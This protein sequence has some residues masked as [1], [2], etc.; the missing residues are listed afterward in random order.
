MKQIGL[1]L[2][3]YHDTHRRFPVGAWPTTGATSWRFL[4][5]PYLEQTS[6]YDLES[7]ARAA[8]T[9]INF[10]LAW[11]PPYTQADFNAY[12][13]PF[14]DLALPVYSCPSSALPT[15]YHIGTNWEEVRTQMMMYV[16]IMGAYPDPLGRANMSYAPER[17]GYATNNGCLLLNESIGIGAITDGTSNTVIIGE[18][19]GNRLYPTVTKISNYFSGW[20]GICCTKKRVGEWEQHHGLGEHI[21]GSSVVA[22]FHTPNPTS[23]GTEANNVWK[24]NT[25]L[26]SYHPG[27]VHALLADGSARFMSDTIGLQTMRNICARDS[28]AAIGE[29]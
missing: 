7:S 8:G 6:L 3:L 17:G 1:A 14:F 29:W 10:T 4:L 16:G 11:K 24:F 18:Q 2:H 28:G 20:S 19:S 22:V 21:Y 25:P 26:S 12:T 27:G 5:L 23:V 9:Y 13:R 15:L